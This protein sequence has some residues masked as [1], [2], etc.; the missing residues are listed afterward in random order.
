MKID[1][2][3]I[4]FVI[5][6]WRQNS[7]IILWTYLETLSPEILSST[8][9]TG[10]HNYYSFLSISLKVFDLIY[11]RA[12]LTKRLAL[13]SNTRDNLEKTDL[14]IL[15][16]YSQVSWIIELRVFNTWRFQVG[17]VTLITNRWRN[18]D[19]L[20]AHKTSKLKLILYFVRSKYHWI[21]WASI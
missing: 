19:V 7:V 18:G 16:F 3:W 2:C 1:A 9:A 4:L 21:P 8:H 13:K 10:C 12:L 11:T 17:R 6:F 20:V 14:L 15:R 5:I